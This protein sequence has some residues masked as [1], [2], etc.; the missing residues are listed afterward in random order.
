MDL[1]LS[2]FE[3]VL[4]LVL[5]VFCAGI[6]GYNRQQKNHSA[7]VR[8]HILVCVGACIIAMIQKEIGFNAL[9]MASRYPHYAGVIRADEA[10]LIAQVVSGVGFLGAGT[11]LVHHHVVRGL[12]TAAS[13]WTVA[14]LGLAV[15]MGNYDIAIAG[16]VVIFLVLGA[17]KRILH[18]TPVKKIMIQ[19][20]HKT[21]TKI[22]IQDYFDE[23]DIVVRDVNFNV[24]Q[25]D[26][27]NHIYTNVYDIEIPSKINFA[28]IIEDISMNENV[29]AIKMVSI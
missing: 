11:I 24:D 15:G 27:N 21:E 13:L 22:F 29:M 19:Y 9:Y 25:A 7:G 18:I 12:T 5:S 20:R 17:L 26:S 2:I 14:G 10:R 4:R 6:I 23:H 1:H 28:D 3:I 8:T 16:T